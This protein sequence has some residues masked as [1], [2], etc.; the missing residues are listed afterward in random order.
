[1]RKIFVVLALVVG[2]A[3][4][5]TERV[6][7]YNGC[8]GSYLRITDGRGH[9]LVER[10]EFGARVSIDLKGVSGEYNRLIL[11]ADGFRVSDGRPL[12]ATSRTFSASGRGGSTAPETYWNIQSLPGGCQR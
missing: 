10:L 5:A 9:Q 6:S 2:L 1:M 12:G 8:A 4:C 7:V 11:N 3:A